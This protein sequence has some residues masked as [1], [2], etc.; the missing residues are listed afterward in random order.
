MTTVVRKDFGP[1]A[2]RYVRVT[3]RDLCPR[4]IPKKASVIATFSGSGIENTAKFTVTGD[5]V[6]QWTYDCS[7]FGDTG[8]FIVS[9]D[10]GSDF[11]G[12]SVNELGSGG[13]GQTHAYGDAGTHYLAVDSECSWTAKVVS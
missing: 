2:A 3:E 13:H 4:Q 6:L 11:S 5:W 9:E 12:A 1:G 10:G 7:A 8:N